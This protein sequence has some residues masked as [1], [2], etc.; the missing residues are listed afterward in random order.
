MNKEPPTNAEIVAGLRKSYPKLNCLEELD[1]KMAALNPKG[2][3]TIRPAK[4][5]EKQIKNSQ[6][7]VKETAVKKVTNVNDN[8]EKNAKLV[9]HVPTTRTVVKLPTMRQ[10][11]TH[12]KLLRRNYE[13]WWMTYGHVAHNMPG[14]REYQRSEI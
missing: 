2:G 10:V 3:Y 8:V 13:Q 6:I 9:P 12:G 1:T 11:F 4:A 5:D 7:V 14:G